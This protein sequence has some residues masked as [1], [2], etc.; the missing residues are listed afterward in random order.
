MCFR[1]QGFLIFL[2]HCLRNSQVRALTCKLLNDM[3]TTDSLA[4]ECHIIRQ[5]AT[6]TL[7]IILL[8]FLNA[9]GKGI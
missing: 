7:G 2:L 9:V 8:W 4:V 5:P 6:Q 1:Q 3:S